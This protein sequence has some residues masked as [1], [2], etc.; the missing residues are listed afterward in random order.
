MVQMTDYVNHFKNKKITLMGLG[1]LG[2]GVGDAKFLAEC[3]ADLLVTDLKTEEK[4]K[5]SLEQL[6]KF[7]NIKYVLGEHRLEDFLGRDLVIKS[8]GIPLDSPYIKEAEK[9]NIPVKMST[10][11]FVTLS[12]TKI[13]GVTGTKGKSTTTHL[14]ESILIESG[15]KFF[16]GGNVRGL[17]TLPLLNEVGEGDIVL[18]ELDSWQLQGFGYDEISPNI[19]VFTNLMNDHMNYYKGNMDQYFN[20]KANIFRYQKEGDVLITSSLVKK[21]IDEKFNK[22]IKSKIITT[23]TLDVP[24]NWKP[25]ILGEHNK[26]SIAFAI[27]VSEVLGIDREII[28]RGVETFKGV[29]GRLELIREVKG[30]KYYNDTTATTTDAAIAALQSLLPRPDFGK[31]SPNIVL[32]AG[33]SDKN[34]VFERF[35]NEMKGRVKKLILFKGNAT[36][37]ILK[38]LEPNQFDFVVI[39]S[40]DKAFEEAQKV[41]EEGDIVLLSPGATSFGIFKN[42]FDRGDQFVELVNK[43]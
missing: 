5:F 14:I 23:S 34:L 13:I 35:V 1:L 12:N 22:E 7:P 32:L 20:D 39:D 18:M 24:E 8:A 11:L 38:L 29:P 16:L 33:G 6:K 21:N 43:L 17:A 30:F 9:N 27:K 3:G 26:E 28:K 2:R 37:K 19:S 41:A 40:M 25:I 15:Q 31:K 10:A 36:D 4:L 42:E